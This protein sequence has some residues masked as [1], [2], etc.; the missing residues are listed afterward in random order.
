M[1]EIEVDFSHMG[2]PGPKRDVYLDWAYD[3]AFKNA[4]VRIM[5]DLYT[6][7]LLVMK[8][9]PYE[10]SPAMYYRLDEF[11]ARLRMNEV[12]AWA[13]LALGDG[14]VLGRVFLDRKFLDVVVDYLGYTYSLS[15]PLSVL[16]W[17]PSKLEAFITHV[18]DHA[19]T[20]KVKGR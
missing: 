6:D 14:A 20:I 7:R 3:P 4:T 12:S 2:D 5:P 8:V 17:L 11:T 18:A 9:G 19:P 1:T 10:L 16:D 13:C 15:M